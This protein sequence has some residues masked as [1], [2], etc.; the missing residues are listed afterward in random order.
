MTLWT[1]I[2]EATYHQRNCTAEG[3]HGPMGEV[4]FHRGIT[5]NAQTSIS[6]DGQ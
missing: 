5:W 1:M 3:G 2:Q 6:R 4:L